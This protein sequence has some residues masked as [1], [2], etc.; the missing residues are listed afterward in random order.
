MN[1][2]LVVKHRRKNPK[3]QHTKPK[4]EC[5]GKKDRRMFICNPDTG[6]YVRR[7]TKKGREIIARLKRKDSTSSSESGTGSDDWYEDDSTDSY[8]SEYNDTP[9]NYTEGTYTYNPQTSYNEKES[10]RLENLRKLSEDE[11][12][13]EISLRKSAIRRLKFLKSRPDFDEREFT[14]N[15]FCKGDDWRNCEFKTLKSIDYQDKDHYFIKG[16]FGEI[17]RA[18]ATKKDGT[19]VK[20]VS[21]LITMPY[22][23]LTKYQQHISDLH[24]EDAYSRYMAGVDIGPKVY[25]SF[26]LTQ[27]YE[28]GNG[29]IHQVFIMDRYDMDCGKALGKAVIE[30]NDAKLE[31]I[32][33]MMIQLLY[34][35]A[36][37][38][39]LICTDIKPGNFCLSRR[40]KKEWWTRY[41]ND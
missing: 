26:Y 13:K 21:K 29:L 16:G 15:F 41:K 5:K 32:I 18:T 25:E 27:E 40:N 7:N 30:K 38:Y 39:E 23:T 14:F 9:S 22:T 1:Y 11:K 28:G 6:R 3:T 17:Y 2:G 34:K 31:I 35:Q 10:L 20:V 24:V 37:T 8:D 12:V 33:K 36:F 19:E 4:K